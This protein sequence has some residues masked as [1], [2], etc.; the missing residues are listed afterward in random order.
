MTIEIRV[1][2][3]PESVSDATLVNWHRSAGD[4]VC[5]DEKLVELETDKVVLEVPSPS[6]GILQEVRVADGATVT[7][8]EVLALL[9]P[10]SGVRSCLRRAGRVGGG[11]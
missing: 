4:P 7:A 2:Q 1:P 9:E 10:G 3:L 8:G 11:V 6:D 5:R